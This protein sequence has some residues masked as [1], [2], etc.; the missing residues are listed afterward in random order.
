MC[1]EGGCSSCLVNACFEDP[2]TK[3]TKNISINSVNHF[4]LNAYDFRALECKSFVFQ[5]AYFRFIRATT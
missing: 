5:S 3:Q 2:V 4:S 1:R